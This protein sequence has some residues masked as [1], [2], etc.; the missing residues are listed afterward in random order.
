MN[1]YAIANGLNSICA[2]TIALIIFLSESRKP[3]QL[4]YAFFSLLLASWS[5]L[6]LIWGF[7]TTREGSALWLNLLEFPICFI[8]MAFFH[9]C[10]ALT[11]TVKRYSK[12]L[13][14]GYGLSLFLLFLN[15]RHA[16]YDFDYVRPM[17]PFL[18]WPHATKWLFLL[19]G[20]E[21]L[22][23]ATGLIINYVALKTTPEP[24]RSTLK[25]HLITAIIGWSGGVTS[26]FYFYD[27]IPIPP[28]GKPCVTFYLLATF[29]LTFKHDLL[30]LNLAVRKTFIYALL[31]VVISLIYTLFIL[32]SERLF[33]S[34]FG[35]KSILGTLIAGAIITIAFNPIRAFITKILDGILFGKNITALSAENFRMREELERQDQMKAIATLAAGMAHEIKNPL[36]TIRTFADFLPSKYDDPTFRAKFQRIVVDEVDR[37]NNIVKQLLEFSRPSDLDLRKVCI[38]DILDETATLLSNN[39]L[40]S[41]IS[42]HK[43]LSEIFL[44]ADKNQLKQVFLNIFINAIQAMPNGGSLTIQATESQGAVKVDVSDTGAGI[45]KNLLSRIFDPFFTTKENG[46][47]LGLSIVHGIVEKHGGKVEIKS[48]VGKGTTVS[49]FLKNRSSYTPSS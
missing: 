19:I 4:T 46:T 36:T 47:G 20:I 32:I 11:N 15:Y 33:Q 10:L 22:Y 44:I 8:H 2:L 31:T 12:L 34:Y 27:S 48:E 30:N 28:V 1:L 21:I 49:V 35:Y 24:Q 41:N 45:S 26:W 37:V 18:Y 43:E 17:G 7:Q 23:V 6:Y 38:K 9:F 39:L 29:Y 14:L 16:F 13:I 5:F 40:N 42:V 3:V 25:S